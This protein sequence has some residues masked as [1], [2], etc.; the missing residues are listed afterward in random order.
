MKRIYHRYEK[1][2]CHKHGFFNN[3]S[4]ENKKE[5]IKKVIDFFSSPELTKE[6]MQ[7]VIEEWQYSCEHNLSNEAMNKV[8]WLGQAAC[9]LYG[10]IPAT[11]TMEAWHKVPK[12]F[13]DVADG[14]ATDIINQYELNHA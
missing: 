10:N 14:I 2:E 4:G 11:V 8:A 9:C 3:S 5:N 1:W 6:F 12:N 13:R 7:R